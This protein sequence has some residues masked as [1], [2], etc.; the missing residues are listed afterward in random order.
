MKQ[1]KLPSSKL[2][3][4]Q[5]MQQDVERIENYF[6]GNE[7]ARISDIE[8]LTGIPRERVYP[9]LKLLGFTHYRRQHTCHW[10]GD[11]DQRPLKR[12][13]SPLPGRLE[14]WF[15][16]RLGGMKILGTLLLANSF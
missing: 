9:L 10:G 8:S 4:Y 1:A 3:Q 12:E 5:E 6:Q 15:I 14:K 11:D 2:L 13:I 16:D 7:C